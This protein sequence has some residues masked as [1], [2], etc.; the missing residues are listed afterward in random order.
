M[1]RAGLGIVLDD[2]DRR[3]GPELGV[4]DGVHDPAQSQVI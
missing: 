3:R 2:E 1:I 4:A